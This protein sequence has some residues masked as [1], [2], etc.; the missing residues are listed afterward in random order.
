METNVRILKDEY[1]SF[2]KELKPLNAYARFVAHNNK[3]RIMVDVMFPEEA[4]PKQDNE[5]VRVIRKFK[6]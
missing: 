2:K 3:E 6:V 5:I 1:D 4:D